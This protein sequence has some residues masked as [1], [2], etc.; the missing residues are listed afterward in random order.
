MERRKAVFLDRDGTLNVLVPFLSRI[1]DF[2]LYPEAPAAVREINDSEYLA[3][4]VTN[5]PQVARGLLTVD[6]LRA[7]HDR[8]EEM[9]GSEGAELDA[10]Y[11]CPHHSDGG[12]TCQC[13][14]P[15]TLLYEQ[16]AE[17]FNIDLSASAVV[18]DSVR[19]VM[20]ARRLGCR[21][22]R[23]KTGRD[24][25]DM[26]TDVEADFVA[27]DLREAVHWLINSK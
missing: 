6:Q 15:G 8:L 4:V 20:A 24:G 27:C 22:V 13:R 25:S 23:V 19:D 18:G 3:I 10:I 21:A 9:L 11:Y 5:Q 2:E 26:P 12:L 7:I 17:R 1:E 14:K 16:A